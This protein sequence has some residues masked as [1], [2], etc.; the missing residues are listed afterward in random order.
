[1]NREYREPEFRVIKVKA[2]DVITDSQDI[3]SDGTGWET[4]GDVPFIPVN[5]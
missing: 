1:M 2:Q 4:G 3:I 5:S